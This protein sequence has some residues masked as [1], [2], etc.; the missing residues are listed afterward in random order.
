MLFRSTTTSGGDYVI[1]GRYVDVSGYRYKLTIDT[2]TGA[3]SW[4][5]GDIPTT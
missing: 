5:S 2:A 1:N 4:T 3:P